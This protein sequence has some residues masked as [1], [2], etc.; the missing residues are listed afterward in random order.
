ME[1]YR[2]GT[3]DDRTAVTDNRSSFSGCLKNQVTYLLVNIS[4]DGGDL[5]I[6]PELL[7]SAAGSR[8]GKHS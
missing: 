1:F 7:L 6:A 5:W 8:R 3:K 4:N 2:Q